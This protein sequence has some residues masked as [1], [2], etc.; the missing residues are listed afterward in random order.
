MPIILVFF[1]KTTA[2]ERGCLMSGIFAPK[3]KK[4]DS[5]FSTGSCPYKIGGLIEIDRLKA[6]WIHRN[7]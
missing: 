3:N 2:T 1:R 6:I 7:R 5:T 4:R